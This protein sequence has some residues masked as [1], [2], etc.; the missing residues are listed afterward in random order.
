MPKTIEQLQAETNKKIQEFIL[1]NYEDVER[2]VLKIVDKKQVII[3]QAQEEA[4]KLQQNEQ[5]E[6]KK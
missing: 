6:T 4:K 1:D 5:K 3:K 2:F